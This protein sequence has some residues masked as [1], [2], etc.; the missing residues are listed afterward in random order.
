LRAHVAILPI[1]R[2]LPTISPSPSDVTTW[3]K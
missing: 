3:T 1:V 2:Q